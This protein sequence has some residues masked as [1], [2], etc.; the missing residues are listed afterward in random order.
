[1]EMFNL[2]DFVIE[3]PP[4]ENSTT[5]NTTQVKIILDILSWN[6]FGNR[7]AT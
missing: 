7:V 3:L 2:A 1:M 6:H 4:K 5:K